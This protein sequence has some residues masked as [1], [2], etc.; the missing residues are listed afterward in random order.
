MK[1]IPLT[2]GMYAQV[3]DADFAL[4]MEFKWFALKGYRTF[5][6]AR[7]VVRDTGKR[8]HL[9]MHQVLCPTKHLV[10]HRNGNGL[11]NSRGNLRP[12]PPGMNKGNSF[13][14]MKNASSKYKGVHWNKSHEQWVARIGTPPNRRLIG[15]FDNEVDA[16]K[17]YDDAASKYYGEFARLN[18]PCP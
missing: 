7:R 17:A 3:D 4:L 11:D 9:F 1:L 18:L 10:D 2:R 6:A 13:K 8:G 12:A 14:R 16:A 5:Y 15:A